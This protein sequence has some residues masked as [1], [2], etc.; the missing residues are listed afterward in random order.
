MKFLNDEIKT[1]SDAQGFIFQLVQHGIVWDL[2]KDPDTATTANGQRAFTDAQGTCV[3]QRIEEAFEVMDD[4]NAY[5]QSLVAPATDA[6]RANGPT[7]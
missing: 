5:M 4:P 7:A 3:D 2:N 1:E 6:N